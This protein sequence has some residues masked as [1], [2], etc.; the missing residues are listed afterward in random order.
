MDRDKLN[1]QVILGL[2]RQRLET[3]ERESED[4]S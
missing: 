1:L 3:D 4:E 2:D